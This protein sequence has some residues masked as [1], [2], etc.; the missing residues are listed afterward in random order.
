MNFQLRKAAVLMLGAVAL[1]LGAGTAHAFFKIEEIP[2]LDKKVAMTKEEFYAKSDLQE[3]EPDD[4]PT[5][6]YRIRLPK[7]WIA[8]PSPKREGEQL[9]SS[10][11]RPITTYIG[12]A[13]GDIRSRIEIREI[14]LKHF[15]SAQNWFLNFILQSAGTIDGLYVKSERRVEAQYTTLE[16][17]NPMTVRTVAQITGHKMVIA[18][19][20][21]PT[22]YEAEEKDLQI[23]TMISFALTSPDEGPIEPTETYTFVDIMKFDYPQSWKLFSPPVT[24]IDRMEASVLNMAG[25]T[26][27]FVDINSMKLNGRVDIK[28]ISKTLG[29]T[30][31]EELAQLKKAFAESSLEIG[32]LVE[33]VKDLKLHKQILK[34]KIDAYL[35]KSPDLNLAGYELWVAVL[36]SQGRFYII[37]LITMGR[38]ENFSR[39]SQ[40]TAT[41]KFMLRTLAPVNDMN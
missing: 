30:E 35:I 5:L 6:S 34:S 7:E 40:N 22:I 10:L 28:V 18:E 17:G 20:L 23:W 16:D 4:D 32:D 37:T 15:I 3:V 31:E 8:L 33:H 26:G 19:Y 24:T 9:S 38:E 27:E 1:L 12:P 11:F 14:D 2:P 21:V 29:T 41:Y 13:R 25:A 39:W 36:E